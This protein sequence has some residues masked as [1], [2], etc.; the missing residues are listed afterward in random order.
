MNEKKEEPEVEAIEYL[1]GKVAGQQKIR[2]RTMEAVFK[3][4][5][6]VYDT[7]VAKKQTDDT[8]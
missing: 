1:P 5:G 8:Q 2:E 3:L 6:M 7:D 4:A